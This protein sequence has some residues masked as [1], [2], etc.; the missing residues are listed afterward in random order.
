MIMQQAIVTELNFLHTMLPWKQ[1]ETTTYTI[2]NS[3][4]QCVSTYSKEFMV[5]YKFQ[6]YLV[7]EGK[8]C[9]EWQTADKR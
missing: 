8:Q 7:Q 3:K 6:S 1:K 4:F 2:P 9:Q 5:K